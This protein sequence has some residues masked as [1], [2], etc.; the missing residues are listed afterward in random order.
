MYWNIKVESGCEN[1]EIALL[2]TRILEMLLKMLYSKDIDSSKI[3]TAQIDFRNNM[4]QINQEVVSQAD[5]P[6]RADLLKKKLA[7]NTFVTKQMQKIPGFWVTSEGNTCG[8]M[9]C[10]KAKVFS[11]NSSPFV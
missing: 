9:L 2:Y 11:S 4:Q 6:D 3:I 10:D 7:A 8:G 1:T 5:I